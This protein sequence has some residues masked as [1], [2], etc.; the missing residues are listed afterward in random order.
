MTRI[1]P[2]HK[3][4]PF[5]L[6]EQVKAILNEKGFSFLFNYSDYTYYKAQAK[7]AFNKAQEIAEYFIQ[8]NNAKSDYDE[9]VF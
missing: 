8:E 4:T 2:S 6:S 1:Q 7:K 3:S 5:K 9:Y